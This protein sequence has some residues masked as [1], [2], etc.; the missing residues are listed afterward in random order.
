EGA[1]L[2]PGREAPNPRLPRPVSPVRIDLRLDRFSI[3]TRI[4]GGFAIVLVLLGV[5]AAI[6]IRSTATVEAQS[7]RVEESG[8]VARLVGDFAYHVGEAR[9]RIVQYALSETDGDLQ[10][11]QQ[12]VAQLQNAAAALKTLRAGNAE[13]GA[14]IGEISEQQAKYAAAVDQM[15]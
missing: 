14:L 6:S 7:A 15:I 8:E 4:L 1:F 12:S 11:A 5:L 13:R 2:P 10:V 3:R 9:M